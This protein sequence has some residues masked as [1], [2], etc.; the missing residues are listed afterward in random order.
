MTITNSN[1]ENAYHYAARIFENSGE[2]MTI[3]FKNNVMQGNNSKGEFEG[4]N[5]SKK[6]STANVYADFAISGNTESLKYRYHKDVT[7]DASCTGA[8][9]F[10]KEQ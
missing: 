8:E 9:L 10:E 7:L 1:F 4:I 6:G 2:R 3:T 5:I